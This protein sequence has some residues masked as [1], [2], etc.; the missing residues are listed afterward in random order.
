MPPRADPELENRILAAARRLWHK[1]GEAALTM[2]AVAKA[3]GTNTPAVYR[4]FRDRDELLL[5]LVESFQM[6]LFRSLEPCRSLSEFGEC[7][8]DFALQRPREYELLMSGLLARIRK[9]RPNFDLLRKRCA[10]WLGGTP[11]KYEDL[12]VALFCFG[13]GA[14]MLIL[15]RNLPPEDVQQVKAVFARSINVLVANA[16]KIRA[17]TQRQ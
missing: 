8:F 7:Y 14:V 17:G 9:R 13:H 16:G 11:D 2:R 5:A 12:A 3:A 4:R 15:T 10:E 6:D 1:N